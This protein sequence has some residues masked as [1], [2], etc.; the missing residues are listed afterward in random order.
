V[1]IFGSIMV[2]LVLKSSVSE[3]V[4]SSLGNFDDNS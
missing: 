4:G 3:V 2:S 1:R